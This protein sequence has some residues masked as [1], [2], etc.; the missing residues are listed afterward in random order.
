MTSIV[1]TLTHADV[2][3]IIRLVQILHASNLQFV[4]IE[5]D[6][7]DVT[8]AKG[9]AT[10][11]DVR[12]VLIASPHVGVFRSEAAKDLRVGSLVDASSTLGS[13]QTLDE[14]NSVKAGMSGKIV[15]DCV[16]DGDFVEFGQPL[17]RIL[18]VTGS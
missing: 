13:I 3:E 7:L 16:R 4:R 12:G 15:E 2:E 10:K 11:A 17:Y 5:A 18:P 9:G 8:V 1:N 6:G 14:K